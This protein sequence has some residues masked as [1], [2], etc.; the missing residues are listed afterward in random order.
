MSDETLSTFLTEAEK[1][2]NDR[3]ITEISDDTSDPEPLSPSKLLLL[4][5]NE[6]LPLGVFEP[7]DNTQ[8]GGGDNHNTLLT[9]FGTDGYVNICQLYRRD[10]NGVY[11]R[12]TSAKEI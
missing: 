11:P 9:Y 10:K 12:E 8:S 4:R 2:L 5:C 3:P 6:S 1:I 7:A